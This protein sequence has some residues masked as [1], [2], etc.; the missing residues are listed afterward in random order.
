[1]PQP[2]RRILLVR[3]SHL[4]DVV[5]ALPVYHALRHAFPE[6][7]LAWAIQ[8]EFSDLVEGLPGLA[9]VLRFDRRG[10]LRAW[11]R[12]RR[13]LSAY[14]A[15]WAV[16]AQGNLKSA[17]VTWLSGAERR[18]G[19]HASLW[20]EPLGAKILDDPTSRIESLGDLHALERS[21]HLA[22]HVA[23]E[24]PIAVLLEDPLALNERE[25]AGGRVRWSEFFDEGAQGPVLL[26]LAAPGDVRAWPVKHQIELLRLLDRAGRPTLAVSGP[27]E[28]AL[29]VRLATELADLSHLRHW[30]AQRGL[31]ELAALFRVAAEHGARLVTCDSGPMHLAAAC[32]LAVVC[33][34]GPQ[35]ANRTGPWPLPGRGSPHAVLRAPTPLS[36]APCR[37]RRCSREDGVLCMANIEPPAVAERLLRPRAPGARATLES[38]RHR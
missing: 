31:R 22:R 13:E 11:Q 15:D 23:P 7:D 4:G 19:L 25:L 34:A 12:L 24:V 9:R 18:S 20:T 8:P 1:L 28:A 35:D 32:D 3:L 5:H 38:R 33:L 30:V 27:G 17:A 10:G 16:D 29:G 37:A 21:L 36:C 14:A 26:Q 2:P 6:A